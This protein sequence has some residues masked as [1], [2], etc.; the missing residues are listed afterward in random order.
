MEA[1]KSKIKVSVNS[2]SGETS[3]LCL[4]TAAFWLCPHMAFPQCVLIETDRER[5]RTEEREKG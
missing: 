1:E 2:V 4:Q 5:D 3:L